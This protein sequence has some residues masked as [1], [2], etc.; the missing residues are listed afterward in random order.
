[1]PGK[2]TI[3]VEGAR[4]IEALKTE[5]D[6][7]YQASIGRPPAAPQPKISSTHGP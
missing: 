4:Q 2:V 1:M 5:L 6:A 7:E 3:K